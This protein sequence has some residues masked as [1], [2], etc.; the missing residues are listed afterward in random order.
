MIEHA[1]F[2]SEA[3]VA[4]QLVHLEHKY[5][6]FQ[7]AIGGVSLWRILRFEIAFA[8][9]NLALE[10]QG[11]PRAEIINSLIRA[12]GQFVSVKPGCRYLG[13]SLSS[14]L[15]SNSELGWRDVY[16]DYIVDHIDGGAKMAYVDA[17]GFA[18]HVRLAYRK[19]I[20]DDTAVFA[21]SAVLG[22]VCGM[23]GN[24]PAFAKVSRVIVEELG[25]PEFTAQRVKRKYDVLLWRARLYRLVLQRIRP[26][27]VLVPNSGQFAL[28]LATRSLGIPFVE[29]QH[30][31]FSP[32]HPD[33]LSAEVLDCDHSTLLL[34][35]L[36]TVYGSH[37]TDRLRDTALGQLDRIRA[38]GSPTIEPARELRATQF[39]ARPDEP[40]LTFTSQG[41]GAAKRSARF[42]TDF[43]S[44]CD[45]SM[46]FNIRL[47]PGYEAE[48]N[49]YLDLAKKDNRV[50][51]WSGN[52]ELSTY[53]M[54]ATSDLHISVSSACHFDALGIGTPTAVLGV[55]G[56]ELVDE[57]VTS[58]KAVFL[59]SPEEF[60][61]V[62]Y[63]RSWGEV[64]LATSNEFFQQNHVQN[65]QAVI[66][67]CEA[68]AT[69]G[70]S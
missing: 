8:M 6:L 66:A 61:R 36:L 12:A 67:E 38:V 39:K 3:D 18:E 54:I 62:I 43:L 17:A 70:A 41:G 32:H 40:I 22:R 16:F 19:P 37:W 13:A 60:G 30:G 65:M 55:A 34:P 25:L 35:D 21:A 57:L 27:V 68:L 11:I 4:S 69:S 47:H 56:Y 1:A 9:Q 28:F 24:D 23:A 63:A 7:L 20:F 26:G 14:A 42:L 15:R 44:G 52:S 64:P 5:D 31:I 58:R 59:G 46:Q 49:A 33:N 10:R 2:R 53:E 45:A 29:M 50:R 48:T 51:L